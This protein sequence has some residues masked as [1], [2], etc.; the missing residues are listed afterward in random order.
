MKHELFSGKYSGRSNYFYEI[1][2]FKVK[3]RAVKVYTNF[4]LINTVLK[5]F[6]LINTDLIKI[7]FLYTQFL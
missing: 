1:R 5:D 3:L 2:Y 4:V 7:L 6:V